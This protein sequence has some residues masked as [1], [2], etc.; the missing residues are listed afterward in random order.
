MLY[1]GGDCS[2][3]DNRQFLK[4]TCEDFGDGPPTEIGTESWI[5]VTDLTGQ[6][7]YHEDFVPVGSNYFLRTPPDQE[8]FVPD[9]IINIYSSSDAT[10]AT[11]LQ[12]MQYHSSCSSNLELKNRFGASQLV[13]FINELQG[14]VTCFNDANFGFEIVVPVTID[15]DAAEIIALTANTNFAGFLDLSDQVAGQVVEPGGS[16]SANI[17]TTFDLTVRQRYT[18]LIQVVASAVP[19]GTICTGTNFTEFLAGNPPPIDSTT[20]APTRGPT[21]S[22]AP[23]P[24]PQ[25]TACSV[26]GV[27]VCQTLDPQGR[28]LSFCDDVGNPADNVCGGDLEATALGFRYNGG[29]NYPESAWITISGGRTGTVVSE[30]VNVGGQVYGEGDFR[31]EAF[32]VVSQLN[33]GGTGPGERIEQFQFDTNCREGEEVL[34]L[35]DIYGSLELTDYRNALGRQSSIAN[36]RMQYFVRNLEGFAMIA[37]DAFVNSDFQILVSDYIPDPTEIEVGPR[38]RVIVHEETRPVDFGAKFVNSETLSF[39]MNVTGRG[40]ISSLECFDELDFSF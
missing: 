36:V 16:I 12:T 38:Q 1:N 33:E 3:S 7:V 35:T 18:L 17:V 20:T 13:E 24:D 25:T 11:L 4:F 2:Q 40:E 34:R 6:I 32:V 39:S 26:E 23:T 28:V 10:E 29:A 27:M 19:T 21:V 30:R 8:R 31:G 37:E 22:P 5:V 9:Q 14:N 15:G